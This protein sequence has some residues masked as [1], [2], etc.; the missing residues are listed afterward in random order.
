MRVLLFFMVCGTA[1]APWWKSCVFSR[2]LSRYKQLCLHRS[3]WGK[4]RQS[5]FDHYGINMAINAPRYTQFPHLTFWVTDY[6]ALGSWSFNVAD[7]RECVGSDGCMK[8]TLNCLLLTPCCR[9]VGINWRMS[10]VLAIAQLVRP[11]KPARLT[12][13]HPGYQRE[14]MTPS[15]TAPSGK[16][17][18]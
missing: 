4:W 18:V 6:T 8:Q 11:Y 9:C 10:S 3:G 17:R 13:S 7:Q 14:E 12:H 15:R 1:C 5:L 16:K 2:G